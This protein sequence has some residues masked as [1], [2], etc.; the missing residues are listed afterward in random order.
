MRYTYG[1]H[2]STILASLAN[3][4]ILFIAVGS[5]GW[6]AIQRFI[7]PVETQGSTISIVAGIGIVINTIS[8]FLF[9]RDKEKDL[10]VKGAYLH[11]LLDALVSV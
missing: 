3:A 2:R 8:A 5:I 9:F 6:E 10:N 4:V 1:F 7:S 11:L